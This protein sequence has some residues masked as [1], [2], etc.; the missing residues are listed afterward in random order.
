MQPIRT[1]LVPTDFSK[2]AGTALD[3]ARTLARDHGARLI[4]LHVDMQYSGTLAMTIDPGTSRKALDAIREQL[5]GSDLKCS[6]E[7]QLRIGDPVDEILEAIATE[8]PDLVVVGSHGRTG[9]RRLIMGSVAEAVLR[10][11]PC[12][13]IT[14]R[15][16]AHLD[17]ATEGGRHGKSVT[18]F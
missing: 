17:D 7:T 13:V 8:N 5:E 6:V 18:V 4:V 2:H 3:V 15:T 11:S 12:P 1:I 10:R 9:L 14:V 16:P